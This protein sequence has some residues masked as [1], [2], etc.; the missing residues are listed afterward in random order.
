[1]Q[2]SLSPSSRPEHDID[3]ALDRVKLALD[4]LGDPQNAYPS[5]HH[6]HERQHIHIRDRLAAGPRSA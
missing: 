2:R 4:I 6:G 1:M 3:P 5:I